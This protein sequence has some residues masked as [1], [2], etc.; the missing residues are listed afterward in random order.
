[1]DMPTIVV[2]RKPDGHF[3]QSVFITGLDGSA[4]HLIVHLRS[5]GIVATVVAGRAGTHL[6]I[7]PWPSCDYRATLAVENDQ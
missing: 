7:V 1:M 5:K 4:L 6:D 3:N 2:N